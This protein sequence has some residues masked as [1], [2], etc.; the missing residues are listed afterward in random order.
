MVFHREPRELREVETLL[1]ERD[2][3][4]SDFR[5]VKQV[6]DQPAHVGDLAIHH[7]ANLGDHR[8]VATPHAEQVNRVPERSE[9]VSQFMRKHGQEFVL[10]L[11]RVLNLSQD[12]VLR[13]SDRFCSVMSVQTPRTC[14]GRCPLDRETRSPDR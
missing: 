9:R 13:S 4:A 8:R 12:R 6:V 11:V 3:T 1:V 7:V 14:A 5:D 10:G 2:Q